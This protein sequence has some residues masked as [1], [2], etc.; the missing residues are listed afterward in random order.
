MIYN[1]GQLIFSEGLIMTQGVHIQAFPGGNIQIGGASTGGTARLEADST[2]A[3]N[4]ALAS[5]NV[6]TVGNN[7]KIV[8]AFA[9]DYTGTIIG[10]HAT[11]SIDAKDIDFDTIKHSYDLHTGILSLSA[12]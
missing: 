4:G 10:F 6:A 8:L 5:T 12:G 9:A 1:H 11:D 7:D 3:F 2:I